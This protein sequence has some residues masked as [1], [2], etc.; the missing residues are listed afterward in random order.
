MK[1][2]GMFMQGV[3]MS[4][5]ALC[6]SIAD[7][8]G[9]ISHRKNGMLISLLII[10]AITVLVHYSFH[11]VIILGLLIFLSGFIFSMLTV[12]GARSSSIGIAALI[13]L[14]LSLESPIYGR[15]IWLN[16]FYIF[17]GGCW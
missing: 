5:G 8:P 9:A 13:V 4:I 3:V 14:V 1:G 16:A 2:L 7:S 12:Y 15:E 11:S 10:P 6:I 17:I